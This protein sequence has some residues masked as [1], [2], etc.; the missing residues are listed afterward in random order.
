MAARAPE[1]VATALAAFGTQIGLAFQVADDVLDSTS[2]SAVLGKTAGLDRARQK[3][4][5]VS[6]LG[7]DGARQEARRLADR[8]V[9]ALEAA[10]LA[11]GALVSLARYIVER[12]S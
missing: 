10:R 3:S 4:T 1:P 6:V 7:V 9:A 11:D 5:Y 8:A 12:T 2:S